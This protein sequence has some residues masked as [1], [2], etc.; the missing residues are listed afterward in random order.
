MERKK[1]IQWSWPERAITF[2]LVFVLF[3]RFFIQAGVS[4]A[5]IYILDIINVYLLLNLF[6][7]RIY[8]KFS[9]LLL[10]YFGLI[11]GS[12]CIAFM[13]YLK[14]GNNILFSV[15]EARNL[16]RFLIFFLSV[17]Q[18]VKEE[19]L[20]KIFSIIEWHFI[21]NSLYIIYLYF[22]YFPETASWMRGDL[23][24]GFFGNMRGGNTFVNVEMLIVV[25]YNLIKWTQKEKS[26]KYLLMITTLSIVVAGLIELKAYFIEVLVI[27]LW[28]VIFVKKS[29]K[30][31]QL[32]IIIVSFGIIAGFCAFRIM[33]REYPW[34]ADVFTVKGLLEAVTSKNYS[35]VDDINRFSGFSTIAEKMFGGNIVDILFGIGLGNGAVSTIAG[36]RTLFSL[37][38]ANSNYSWFSGTHIFVQCGLIGLILYIS[39]FVVLLRKKKYNKYR[40]VS[41]IILLLSIFLVFYGEALKTDA[42]YLLYFAIGSGFM[43]NG[44]K[45]DSEGDLDVIIDNY[46]SL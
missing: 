3:E 2:Q 41:D 30:E 24:N 20:D 33:I 1:Y 46:T 45:K 26:L 42:G 28:Y 23:L 8:Q 7:G 11:I 27:Y 6:V 19:H 34:F 5:I 39:T 32:N 13:N 4:N 29:R 15:L 37:K 17:T 18:Y 9:S 12:L 14:Y 31:K 25:V 44:I 10:I 36:K 38:F 16:I 43:K 40:T 22:T 35:S 21:V